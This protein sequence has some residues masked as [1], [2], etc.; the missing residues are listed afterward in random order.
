MQS[1][2]SGHGWRRLS[3]LSC[4]LGLLFAFIVV[5][6]LILFVGFRVYNSLS[7]EIVRLDEQVERAQDQF[8]RAIGQQ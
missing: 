6:G 3:K 1:P 8:D 4:G 2:N 7:D 5:F